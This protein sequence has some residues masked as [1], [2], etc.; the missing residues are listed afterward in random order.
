M[1]EKMVSL[2]MKIISGRFVSIKIQ[3][4]NW[5]EVLMYYVGSG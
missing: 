2:N 4:S 1:E 3:P 5:Q